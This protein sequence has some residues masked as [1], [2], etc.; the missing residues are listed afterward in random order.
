MCVRT[1]TPGGSRRRGPSARS[2]SA[3][4]AAVELKLVDDVQRLLE[5]AEHVLLEESDVDVE[6]LLAPVL[7]FRPD[8]VGEKVLDEGTLDRRPPPAALGVGQEALGAGD[9]RVGARLAHLWAARDV[10]AGGAHLLALEVLQQL[11]L[12]ECPPLE[13]HQ[14]LGPAGEGL[15]DLLLRRHVWEVGLDARDS[16]GEDDVAAADDLGGVAVLIG[17][18]RHER[19]RLVGQPVPDA[20]RPGRVDAKLGDV[21]EGGEVPDRLQDPVAGP[22]QLPLDLKGEPRDEP[23]ARPLDD[24]AMDGLDRQRR[25]PVE[26]GEECL[27][28]LGQVVAIDKARR[29]GDVTHPEHAPVPVDGQ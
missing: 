24:L 28:V 22:S 3:G 20:E 15:D 26:A 2:V 12:R 4:A 27:D 6:R 29:A 11:R 7:P 8:E 1:W 13:V 14:V 25:D 23:V 10:Q 9:P 17:G 19:V 16:E 5:R 21:D 18:K